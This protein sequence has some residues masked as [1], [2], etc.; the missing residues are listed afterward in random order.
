MTAKF[1]IPPACAARQLPT[2]FKPFLNLRLNGRSCR[3]R[4]FTA[5]APLGSNAPIGAVRRTIGRSQ[6]PLFFHVANGC[7]QGG[8]SLDRTFD[9]MLHSYLKK[10]TLWSFWASP[11]NR[12]GR[13]RE[14]SAVRQAPLHYTALG[15][16]GFI[17]TPT[18]N[19]LVGVYSYHRLTTLPSAQLVIQ[20]SSPSP[21]EAL[22]PEAPYVTRS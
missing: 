22:L 20:A 4:P 19:A 11:H 8:K 18:F 12:I 6:K 2:Q 21:F 15:D 1:Q 5:G 10:K 17:V 7:E 3:S 13:A 14:Q 16:G 9:H